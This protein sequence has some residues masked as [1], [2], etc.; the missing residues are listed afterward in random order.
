MINFHCKCFNSLHLLAALEKG[1]FFLAA[2][3]ENRY[4]LRNMV[5]ISC[6]YGDRRYASV[7]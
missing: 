5:K 3:I 4:F 6:E 2:I 7:G 1:F